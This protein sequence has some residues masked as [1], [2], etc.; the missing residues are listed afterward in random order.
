MVYLPDEAHTAIICGN[1]NC[2]KTKFVLDLLEGVYHKT[3]DNIVI[4]CPT[5]ND[6]KTYQERE[7]VKKMCVNIN[8]GNNFNEVLDKE[9]KKN[10][11][12]KT[13]YIIDDCVNYKD[14]NK[15]KSV[16]P[17]LVMEGRHTLQ[18]VWILTQKYNAVLKDVRE[19]TAWVAIFYCKDKHLLKECLDENDVVENEK[20]PEIKKEL[21]EKPHSKLVIVTTNKNRGYKIF[22]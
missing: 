8:P 13:L 5:F 17:K 2:G 21:R 18:S 22:P 11:N 10:K 7:W 9:W 6:N 1:T 20:I 14:T 3:F 12:T 4:I 15:E 19:N 16:L